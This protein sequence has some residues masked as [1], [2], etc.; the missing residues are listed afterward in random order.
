MLAA[1]LLLACAPLA[2]P[3]LAEALVT[4]IVADPLTGVAMAAPIRSPISPSPSRSREMPAYEY[5]WGGVPW[6]FIS[7]AN[8]D[9]FMRAPEIPAARSS[10]GTAGSVS[11]A[12]TSRT[13]S[14]VST[15]SR[16]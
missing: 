3:A 6:Y 16:R 2:G 12:A 11:P 15:P 8:R 10:A 14:R 9:V 4:T 13:A 7:E 5:Y 1:G